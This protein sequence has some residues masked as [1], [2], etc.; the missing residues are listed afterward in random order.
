M[1]KR[2]RVRRDRT[3]RE[4]FWLGQ[5]RKIE[6]AGI[7]SRTH[8]QRAGL[9]IGALYQARKRLVALGVWPEPKARPLFAPV[10]VLEASPPGPACRLRLASG[11]VL[12]WSAVPAPEVLA[13]LLERM[14]GV[15]VSDHRER[16]DRTIVN[17]QIGIV[18]AKIGH[19][20]HLDRAS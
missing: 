1:A 18:N 9:S 6:S 8:A 15:R 12:E 10:R 14:G 20:E 2:T 4:Q 3:A 7:A 5:L 16:Q 19:G 17:T 13:V 11:A